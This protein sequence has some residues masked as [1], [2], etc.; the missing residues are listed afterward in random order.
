M[1]HALKFTNVE[2]S[3]ITMTGYDT[4]KY[5]GSVGTR[6]VQSQISWKAH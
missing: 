5:S 6:H 1:G 3:R 2:T 4:L